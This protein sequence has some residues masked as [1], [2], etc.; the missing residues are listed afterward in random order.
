MIIFSRSIIIIII[1]IIN[2]YFSVLHEQPNGHLHT[3]HRNYSNSNNVEDEMTCHTGNH[4]GHSNYERTEERNVWKKIPGKHSTDS[5]QK[6]SVLG[7]SHIIKKVP[8]SETWS[9]VVGFTVRLRGEGTAIKNIIY[10]NNIQNLSPTCQE[11]H[12]S[13]SVLFALN[14]NVPKL[15]LSYS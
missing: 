6:A 5:L 14:W 13:L 2:Y 10:Y 12:I 3:Q 11:P 7:T 8:Q 1:I 4:W 15:F 9:L